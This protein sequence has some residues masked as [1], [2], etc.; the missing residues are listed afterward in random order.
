MSTDNAANESSLRGVLAVHAEDRAGYYAALCRLGGRHGV[1]WDDD[2]QAWVVTSYAWCRKLLTS[3]VLS[4]SRLQLAAHDLHPPLQDVARRAQ[5][6]IDLQMTFD[7]SPAA[8]RWHRQ[9]ARL[10]SAGRTGGLARE[11]ARNADAVWDSF[12]QV[13]GDFYRAALRPYVSRA[14]AAP[15]GLAEDARSALFPLVYGYADF[16]D[17]KADSGSE[18]GAAV[19]VAL[20]ADFVAAHV[21]ELRRCA[22]EPIEDENRWMADYILT[23]VAGHE[24]TA[25]ALA[26]CLIEAC[27]RPDA[28]GSPA[29]IRKHLREALRFDSPI[30][31]IGRVARAEF[32]FRDGPTVRSGE[33]VFLHVGAANRDPEHFKQADRFCPERQE[34]DMLSFGCGASRCVGMQLSLLQAQ[35][36]LAAAARFI[37]SRRL[38]VE[39]S[40]C[41]HGLAGRSFERLRLAI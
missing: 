34:R 20:L 19:S 25:Y 8:A 3:S 38:V 36:F 29:A 26:V 41:A 27:E 40:S 33:R 18:M 28:L 35:I 10:L 30:Q 11:L 4:K 2:L 7:E 5:A 16:L 32:A 15:L 39:S 22:R 23:L 17:G 1:F 14:V 13:R 24:S 37:A 6:V 31:M 9:W 21:G 12:A